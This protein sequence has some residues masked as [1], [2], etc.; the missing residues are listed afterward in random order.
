MNQM[1]NKKFE[2]IGRSRILKENVLYRGNW[3]EMVELE[4]EV[5]EKTV[6]KF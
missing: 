2:Q 6:R 3:T 4:Y 5:E 1:I